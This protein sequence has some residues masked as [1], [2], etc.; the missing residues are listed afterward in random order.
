MKNL[1]LIFSFLLLSHLASAQM[2]MPDHIKEKMTY[3]VLDFAPWVGVIPITD[4]VMSY[5]PSLT[6]KI[7][8]DVYGSL[9]DSTKIHEPFTEIARTYNLHIANGVPA[10]K[11]KIAA[12]IHGGLSKAVMSNDAY[13]EK[14]KID[15]PTILAL[16]ELK[17]VGVEF[18]LCGQSM[19][20]LKIPQEDVTPEVKVAMSAKTTFV[21]LDQMGYTYMDV[22]GD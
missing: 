10:D 22:S 2:T 4:P 21:A 13:R 11:I 7:A 12:V 8:I 16:Q 17:K 15:N 20:F 9:K 14:Y 3:P 5:D 19:S 1:L 6:Y 18:Y